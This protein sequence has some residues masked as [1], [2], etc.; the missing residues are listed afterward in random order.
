MMSSLLVGMTYEVCER[1]CIE[2]G[3]YTQ[4]LGSALVLGQRSAG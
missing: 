3:C 1:G 2:D 4:T